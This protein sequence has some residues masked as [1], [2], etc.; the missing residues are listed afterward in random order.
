MTKHAAA[1]TEK[2]T[3]DFLG[4]VW[5]PKHDLD[6]IDEVRDVFASPSG[7]RVVARWICSGRNCRLAECWVERGGPE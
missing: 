2:F 4:R 3:R 5:G 1:A 7:D 6:A